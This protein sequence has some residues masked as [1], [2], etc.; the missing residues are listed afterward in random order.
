ML[1][2][3]VVLED[4]RNA[5]LLNNTAESGVLQFTLNTLPAGSGCAQAV[6]SFAKQVWL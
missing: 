6:G 1:A 2:A 3:E 4:A 5:R